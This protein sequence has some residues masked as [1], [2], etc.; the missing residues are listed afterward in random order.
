MVFSFIYFKIHTIPLLKHAASYRKKIYYTYWYGQG[1]QNVRTLETSKTILE[2]GSFPSRRFSWNFRLPRHINTRWDFIFNRKNCPVLSK[3]RDKHNI[4]YVC[5]KW[6]RDTNLLP[7]RSVM[8]PA[9][10]GD[11]FSVLSLNTSNVC[12]DDSYLLISPAKL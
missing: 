12:V 1:K 2:R 10:S 9:F 11:A 5:P 3:V 4:I 8:H 6:N 7:W